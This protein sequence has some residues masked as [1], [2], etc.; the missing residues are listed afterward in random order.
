MPEV[1]IKGGLRV[2]IP[3]R[4]EIRSDVGEEIDAQ[5][6]RL[7]RGFKWMRLPMVQNTAASSA[8]LSGK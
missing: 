5:E 8:G 4:Q 3:S 2:E 1:E 7:A 6:R